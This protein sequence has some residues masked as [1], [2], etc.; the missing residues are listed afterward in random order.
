M[1]LGPANAYSSRL[2]VDWRGLPLC[3]AIDELAQ[4]ATPTHSR[5]SSSY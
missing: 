5:G 1:W 4:E 3:L 2:Q